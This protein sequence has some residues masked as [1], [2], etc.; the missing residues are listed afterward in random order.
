MQAPIWTMME[1]RLGSDGIWMANRDNGTWGGEWVRNEGAKGI[2]YVS[3][4][5]GMNWWSD[6]S[7]DMDQLRKTVIEEGIHAWFDIDVSHGPD[8][9]AETLAAMEQARGFCGKYD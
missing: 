9:T 7:P 2:V 6:G 5:P 1:S 8:Q 4:S 3:S